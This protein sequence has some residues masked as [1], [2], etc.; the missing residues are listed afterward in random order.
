MKPILLAIAAMALYAIDS[1]LIDRYYGKVHPIATLF[2]IY[3]LLLPL[4]TILYFFGGTIGI[5]IERPTKDMYKWIGIGA[6]L[7]V[8]AELCLFSS[9]HYGASLAVV[10]TLALLIPVFGSLFKAAM[11]WGYPNRYTYLAMITGAITVIFVAL[12]ILKDNSK[13]S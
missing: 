8:M 5:E 7:F 10:T 13:G 11:Q 9:Y 6:L 4:M 3:L 12:S 1:V 2:H